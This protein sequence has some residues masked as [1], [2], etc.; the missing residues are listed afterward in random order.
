VEYL[1]TVQTLA[2]VGVLVKLAKAANADRK[3]TP[4]EWSNILSNGVIPLL[5]IH[6]VHVT[7]EPTTALATEVRTDVDQ[8]IA[9]VRNIPGL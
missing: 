9:R 3:I 7:V 1:K 5:A 4:Q 6:G 8:A 2:A